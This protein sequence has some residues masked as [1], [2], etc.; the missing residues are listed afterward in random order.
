MSS[1]LIISHQSVN[2]LRWT[3]MRGL[4]S[5]GAHNFVTNPNRS[6]T[7]EFVHIQKVNVQ[8]GI[9]AGVISARSIGRS[10]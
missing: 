5:W 10:H 2:Q 1:P 9:P 6:N 8:G 4:I 3:Q 7:S